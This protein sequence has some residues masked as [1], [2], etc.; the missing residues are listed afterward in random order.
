MRVPINI[1]NFPTFILLHSYIKLAKHK[2]GQI[3]SF[4]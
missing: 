4:T 2:T 3:T 1:N